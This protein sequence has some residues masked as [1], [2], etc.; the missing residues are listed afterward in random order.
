MPPEVYGLATIAFMAGSGLG[1]VLLARWRDQVRRDA[2][3]QSFRV[4]WPRD[5][6]SKHAFAFL[7]AIAG[8]PRQRFPWRGQ[9]TI[10]FELWS[11]PGELEHRLLV[12][13]G[14]T[15]FVI[16]QLRAHVPS[17]RIEPVDVVPPMDLQAAVELR[18]SDPARELRTDT[19]EASS[20]ALLAAL[21]PLQPD[22][23]VVVQWLIGPGIIAAIPDPLPG[24][25]PPT[26]TE[27]LLGSRND[28]PAERT[29]R[30][31][32]R[33]K[34]TAPIFHAVGRVAVAGATRQRRGHLLWR[35]M[36]VLRS[37]QAPGVTLQRRYLPQS[38][39]VR[40]TQDGAQP[41][42]RGT[43][44][45]ERAGVVD[46]ARVAPRRCSDTGAGV[47]RWTPTATG[48]RTASKWTCHRRSDI[49]WSGATGRLV[50]RRRHVAQPCDRPNR[51]R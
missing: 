36:S 35:V 1:L 20:A 9:S 38:W 25:H 17:A 48:A 13:Q 34:Q 4:V 42:V 37:V 3:R 16:G 14:Q 8:L 22:E 33:S 43:G 41:L 26:M 28:S 2:A 46:R 12:P 24:Q 31:E 45:V 7:A 11:R 50:G 5:V 21:Q 40:R 6:D 15:G 29:A 51:R 23:A 49:P 27:R 18:L 32:A 39:L 44:A 10:A 30:Q 47:R 19:S